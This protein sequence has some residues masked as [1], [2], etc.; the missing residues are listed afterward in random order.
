MS[1]L[2]IQLTQA[3]WQQVDIVSVRKGLH[4]PKYLKE[5]L[6]K[7]LRKSQHL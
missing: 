3:E 1:A 4:P 7:D 2:Q 6:M 5:L